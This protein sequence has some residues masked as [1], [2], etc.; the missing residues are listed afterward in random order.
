MKEL[1]KMTDFELSKA[2][3]DIVGASGVIRLAETLRTIRPY[4]TDLNAICKVVDGLRQLDGPEWFDYQYHLMEVC[5]T[6]MNCVQASARIRAETYLK[7]IRSEE[8]R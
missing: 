6:V 5:G 2:V 3:A 8:Y 7:T 1:S 4:S